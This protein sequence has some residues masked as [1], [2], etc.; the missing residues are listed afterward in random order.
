MGIETNHYSLPPDVERLL[1]LDKSWLMRLGVIDLL[2]DCE[3]A[4]MLQDAHEGV[5]T[6]VQALIHAGEQ[7]R[8]GT[9][10]EVGESGTLYRFL[11]FAAWKSGDDREFIR[12]GTLKDRDIVQDPEIV[13]LPL[14]KLLKLDNG[15]SQWAS[16]AVL[17][18]SK[19]PSPQPIPYKLQLTYEAMD[20]WVAAR[21][22]G[23]PWEA[24]TDA[25]I[26]KQ[27]EAYVRYLETGELLFE[28]EQAEDYCF[29]RAFGLITPEDGEARWPSLRQHESDRIVSMEEALAQQ[30]V[31]SRDHR[32][33]QAVAML[34]GHRVLYEHPEAVNKSWP[35][36]W[37]IIS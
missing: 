11:Q 28:P 12:S 7:W 20:H 21:T 3:P 35:A 15:T 2:L 6:D 33:V 26:A 23:K 29:A 8:D 31:T 1:P 9:A 32:V 16:A 5:G 27:A 22:E 37:G 18:G 25:T 36:F 10:I 19:E 34:K 14:V 30:V 4:V 24:K 13:H 17:T